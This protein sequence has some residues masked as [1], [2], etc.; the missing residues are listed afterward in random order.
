MVRAQESLNY[1]C[2]SESLAAFIKI[3]V[4]ASQWSSNIGIGYRLCRWWRAG[5]SSNV[6]R[7][8]RQIFS[9]KIY[10]FCRA[11]RSSWVMTTTLKLKIY[12]SQWC[13]RVSFCGPR[14]CWQKQLCS[15]AEGPLPASKRRKP[16]K[17]GEAE[18][19]PG[20][21]LPAGLKRDKRD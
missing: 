20:S 14:W 18:Q 17:T 11:H 19:S 12:P 3:P 2:S 15:R 13:S 16:W 9:H 21:K 1:L 5:T 7:T 4:A 6:K 10:K 8:L